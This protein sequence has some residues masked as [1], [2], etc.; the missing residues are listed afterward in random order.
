MARLASALFTLSVLAVFG[1]A[2]P[3]TTKSALDLTTEIYGPLRSWK[4]IK[5]I[6]ID[7]KMTIDGKPVN[8]SFIIGYQPPQLS[9]DEQEKKFAQLRNL[10]ANNSEST[11]AKRERSWC[12]VSAD[13]TLVAK[14]QLQPSITYFCYTSPATGWWYWWPRSSDNSWQPFT[15]KD[16]LQRP[17]WFGGSVR[18]GY[19]FSGYNCWSAFSEIFILPHSLLCFKGYQC[20]DLRCN[21]ATIVMD[22]WAACLV[23]ISQQILAITNHPVLPPGIVIGDW[24]IDVDPKMMVD[25][26]PVHDSFI[27][28]HQVPQLSNE[29]DKR[30]KYSE[31]FE[32]VAQLNSSG[33]P[34]R[35]PP[36]L[37]KRGGIYPR[38][39]VGADDAMVPVEQLRVA[40]HA[41]AITW[42]R[43]SMGSR[44]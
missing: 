27:V 7:P 18:A 15:T 11:L 29:R 8:D 28:G 23:S 39:G 30:M 22:I 5:A 19:S 3:P 21:A 10:V 43:R 40:V 6:D 1:S 24:A 33:V 44:A 13:H 35:P 25:G 26:K 38:C 4:P 9:A 37:A 16:G 12:G 31:L 32:L 20:E 36:A 41:L 17:V 42:L 2:K 34:P 14:A